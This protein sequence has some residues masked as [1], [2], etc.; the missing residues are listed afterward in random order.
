MQKIPALTVTNLTITY[1]A[2]P[3]ISDVSVVVP[4]GIMLGIIG[5]NGAGKTTF[6][7]AVVGLVAPTSGTI[8]VMGKPCQDVRNLYAYI[9]QKNSIDWDFP[10]TVF[11]MV[12]MGCYG[13][14]GWFKRPKKEYYAQAHEVIAA[15]GLEHVAYCSIGI[16]SGGQRQRAFVARALMQDVQI[17]F[18]DEPF[19]GIDSKTEESIIDLLKELRDQGKTIIMVHHDL[20]TAPVFF[21]WALL[22]NK[23]CTTIGPVSDVLTRENLVRVYNNDFL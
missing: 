13:K 16:L 6:L 1:N 8:A 19:A 2:V 20:H 9:P 11:D 5:P 15:V 7:K 18:F 14:L 12:L 22:L 21:D 17:Y 23:R 10:I 4:Q 3:I